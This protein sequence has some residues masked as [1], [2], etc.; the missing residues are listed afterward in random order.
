MATVESDISEA[1]SLIYIELILYTYKAR[2][3][4]LDVGAGIR[5]MDSKRRR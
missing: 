3:I 5:L 4:T 1:K 2:P